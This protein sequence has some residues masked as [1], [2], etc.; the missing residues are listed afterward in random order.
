[1]GF[2]DV[3][4]E[5]RST[6]QLARDLTDGPGP[7]SVGEAGAAWVRV[8][9]ELASVSTDFDAVL[10]RFK[11]A[12]D[13]QGAAAALRRLEEFGSWL[14][15]VS[16]S[17][18]ANGQRAEAAAVANT[19]AVLAMPTVAEAV[20]AKAAHDMMDS[21][22]A[23]NGAILTGQ[24]AEFDEAAAG[25]QSDAAI[26]MHQYED[27]CSALA[28]RWDQP[29]PPRITG[30]AADKDTT[31]PA[32]AHAG[33]AGGS[34][35][36]APGI[37]GGAAAPPPPLA[38]WKPNGPNSSQD[39]RAPQKMPSAVTAASTGYGAGA[40][41]APLAGHVRGDTDREFESVRPAAALDGGGEAGIAAP[42]D[43]H[44][45]PD[46]QQT[47][48]PFVVSQVSWGANTA[49]FDE[50]V[51]ADE[52]AAPEFD[53]PERTLEAVSDRWVAPPVIGVDKKLTL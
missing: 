28:E 45:L 18:A 19:V 38:P 17:A 14:Q 4:W 26:V 36:A 6:E 16:L 32:D 22:A 10:E 46:A 31:S 8:A 29:M 41:Y 15:A 52:P 39:T 1:M 27:A 35:A 23:Y 37:N 21:L 44:W 48:A 24:F 20:Q 33:G 11:A 50:L 30:S 25:Q 13:S 12:N 47:D 34:H 5:S 43:Q 49:L 2:T 53:H 7:S 9:D 51:T 3:A 42:E 40:P